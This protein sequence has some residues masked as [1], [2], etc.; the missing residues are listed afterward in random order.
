MILFVNNNI[1]VAFLSYTQII[2]PPEV[3]P[4]HGHG[5]MT[6]ERAKVREKDLVLAQIERED[7]EVLILASQII[8][9]Y[10]TFGLS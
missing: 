2:I 7:D 9:R 4:S 3:V 8:M 6:P 5:G 1:G 10:G